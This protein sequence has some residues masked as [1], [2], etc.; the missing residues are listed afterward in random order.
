MIYTF[1]KKGDN[2]FFRIIFL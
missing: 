1:D 2:F